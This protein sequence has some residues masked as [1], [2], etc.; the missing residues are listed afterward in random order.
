M[1]TRLTFTVFFLPV[2][3]SCTSTKQDDQTAFSAPVQIK[4]T[5]FPVDY[6]VRRLLPTADIECI[7]PV[8]EDPPD[9]NPKIETI[10]NLQKATAIVAN[11]A[12]FEKWME[13]ASL[14][15]SKIIY[16][17]QGL[18]EQDLIFLQ[19]ETHSHG[20]KGA[21][22]HAGK[23]PHIWSDPLLYQKQPEYI[24]QQLK[25]VGDSK[26]IE[27][28]LQTLQED[29]QNLHQA[30]TEVTLQYRT[31]EFGANHPAY[32]YLAKRYELNIRSFDFDPQEPFAINEMDDFFTWN[33]SQAT[34]QMLWEEFP[35]K[36]VQKT[37]PKNV[38]HVYIDPLEQPTEKKYNYIE[39]MNVNIERF[40]DLQTTKS[41]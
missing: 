37:F 13:T 14:P 41:D 29:L 24:A 25:K 4:T 40:K 10:E 2:L 16:A 33:K 19:G 5:S 12:G 27:T 8:G 9:W 6:L 23:D 31:V 28:N 38:V 34:V 39:Q 15:Q 11:G 32:N 18:A 20:K 17:E 7:I 35:S 36:E 22:S 1:Q 30:L 21:H 26:E 3:W